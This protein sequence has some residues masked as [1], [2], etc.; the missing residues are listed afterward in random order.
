M[1]YLHDS[2]N[3]ATSGRDGS[4]YVRNAQS[5]NFDQ[6]RIPIPPRKTMPEVIVSRFNGRR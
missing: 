2:S 6:T 5:S 4:Q 1:L 3:L